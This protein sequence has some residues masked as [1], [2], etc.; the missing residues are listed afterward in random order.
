MKK[1]F[2][3]AV[4]SSVMAMA[5]VASDAWAGVVVPPIKAEPNNAAQATGSKSNSVEQWQQAIATPPEGHISERTKSAMQEAL[6]AA[7]QAGRLQSL[8]PIAGSNGE[9]LYPYGNSLPTLVT[10]PLHTSIVILQPGCHPAEATGA[11]ASEWAVHPVMAGNQPELTIMPKFAGLHTDLIIPATSASGKP[12]NYVIQVTSDSN[13]Y[14]PLL[15]FY[16]PASDVRHWQQDAQ[17][18]KAAL[19]QAQDMTVASLPALSVANLD[20]HWKIHCGGGGWFSSSDCKDIAPVRTFS[21]RDHTYLQFRQDQ[22]DH[23]GIP[24]IMAENS[25]GQ[26]AIINAQFRDGYYVVDSVPHEILLI[27]GKNGHKRV[28]K[29][30]RDSGED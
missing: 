23:G 4:F 28:V 11:P 12:L 25:A 18:N 19:T 3:L 8:P 30:V 21:S 10:A 26:P 24:A 15:G 14:T 1:N 9:I 7:W 20:F 29:V 22:A 6:V 2:H 17:S 5:L 13:K 27:A 16:Y